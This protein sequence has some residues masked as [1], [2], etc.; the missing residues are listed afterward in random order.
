MKK[1]DNAMCL[2]KSWLNRK[3]K[4]EGK[5]A[6]NQSDSIQPK[7]HVDGLEESQKET[8]LHCDDQM[9]QGKQFCSFMSFFTQKYD[10]M[11][12]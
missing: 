4:K 7:D 12:C 11:E 6:K 9:S 5:F 1:N 2:Q 3:K 8:V 10:W